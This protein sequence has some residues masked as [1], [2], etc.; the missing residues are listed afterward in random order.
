MSD[1]VGII[2]LV[3]VA[4]VVLIDICLDYAVLTYMIKNFKA[5]LGMTSDKNG[6][7]LEEQTCANASACCKLVDPATGPVPTYLEDVKQTA[8]IP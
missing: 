6:N 1:V 7:K 4:I 3:I 8:Q 2:I 5:L